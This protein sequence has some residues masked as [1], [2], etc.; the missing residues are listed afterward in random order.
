MSKT[1]RFVVTLV[2]IALVLLSHLRAL[3]DHGLKVTE[4][5]LSRALVTFGVSRGLNGVISVVQGTEVA[6]EPV[7]AEIKLALPTE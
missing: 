6:V 1:W 2:A 5:G 7:S 4:N 3:D